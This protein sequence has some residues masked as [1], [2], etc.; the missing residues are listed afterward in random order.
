MQIVEYPVEKVFS[1]T[2]M[3]LLFFWQCAVANWLPSSVS[4]GFQ[5]GACWDREGG[6]HT[7]VAIHEFFA[8]PSYSFYVPSDIACLDISLQYEVSQS[9]VEV[10]K[11]CMPSHF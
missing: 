11:V 5:G 8:F 1:I 2:E 9:V 10:E 4:G 3:L 6:F 7:A